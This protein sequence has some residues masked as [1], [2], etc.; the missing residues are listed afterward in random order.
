MK[1]L[2]RRT[3]LKVLTPVLAVVLF[4]VSFIGLAYRDLQ[5]QVDR[6]DVIAQLGSDRPTRNDAV[7]D[8][9]AGH[10]I[11][12]LVLGSDSRAGNNNVDGS[13]GN[14]EVLVARSDTAMIMHIA[15]DRSRID[16]VSIPRDTLVSIPTCE[17]KD[18]TTTAQVNRTMFNS[19]FANGAGTGNDSQAIADGAAC[20]WKTAEKLTDIHIDEFMVVDFAGLQTMVDTLGGVTLYV[21]E[22]IDDKDYTQLK[23][24]VGCHHLSG[25]QALD[26]AR[27]RHGV[28]DGS[29]IGRISRQQNLMSAMFRTLQD[30]NVLTNA[31]DLYSFTRSSLNTLTT[32]EK[33]GQLTTL[34]GLGQSV[35]NV[36]LDNINF[37]T[38]P[39]T[40]APWDSYRVVPSDEA[41]AVWAALREDQP[42]PEQSVTTQADGQTP[43]PSQ[44]PDEAPAPGTTGSGTTAPEQDP[45]T[46]PASPS[47]SEDPAA[48]CR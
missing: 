19:A 22:S 47:P 7:A 10:A 24:P 26:Y 18:G 27:V 4:A 44:A 20:S 13:E 31:N 21:D 41:E 40:P 36:G 37:I 12:I 23:L 16:V 17:R 28:G 33:I 48:A 8:N 43:A 39:S 30:K 38:M 29:D 9:Y 11:N 14:E 2:A 25:Q 45:G 32:S 1:D 5:N 42:V 46:A 3:G 6:H 34:A 35:A 15:A